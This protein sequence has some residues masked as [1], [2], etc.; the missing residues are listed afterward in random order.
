ME[1]CSLWWLSMIQVLSLSP[2]WKKLSIFLARNQI[3]FP[4]VAEFHLK[5]RDVFHKPTTS[6][7]FS[8]LVFEQLR[9]TLLLKMLFKLIWGR[10]YCFLLHSFDSIPTFVPEALWYCPLRPIILSSQDH[11]LFLAYPFNGS[12][13]PSFQVLPILSRFCLPFPTGVLS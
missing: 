3:L 1:C 9:S 13:V 6:L 7:L 5:F 8:L 4:L 2:R 11:V 10:R 12:I